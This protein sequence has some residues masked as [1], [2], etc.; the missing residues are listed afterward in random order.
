MWF[1]VLKGTGVVPGGPRPLAEEALAEQAVEQPEVQ[2]PHLTEADLRAARQDGYE[3]GLAEGRAAAAS[4]HARAVERLAAEQRQALS[5]LRIAFDEELVGLNKQAADLALSV[6]E[7]VTR[8]K[9][10]RSRTLVRGLVDAALTEIEEHQ[11]VTVALSPKDL[12]AVEKSTQAHGFEVTFKA[13]RE[14][15][16]GSFVIETERETVDGRLDRLFQRLRGRLREVLDS[17][18]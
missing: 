14:L 17:A 2:P 15:P 1:K 16:A 9:L 10:S 6:A 18:S 4:E 12:R 13:D 3:V 8:A 5:D 7:W 11:D